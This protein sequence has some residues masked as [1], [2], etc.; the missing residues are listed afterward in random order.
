MRNALCLMK[1][2]LLSAAAG[3]AQPVAGFAQTNDPANWSVARE[4]RE[5]LIA[6]TK[7][8]IDR[9]VAP[10]DEPGREA[11][12]RGNAGHHSHA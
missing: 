4:H 6:A 2:A 8:W 10:E 3:L 5:T 12:P 11:P 7:T 9:H 1:I